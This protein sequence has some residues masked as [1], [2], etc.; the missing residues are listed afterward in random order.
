MKRQGR[1]RVIVAALLAVPLLLAACGGSANEE[2]GP[3]PATIE[4]V[5]GTDV[6]RVK[7]TS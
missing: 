7:L 6:T 2:A 3:D 5:K 4:H 1:D